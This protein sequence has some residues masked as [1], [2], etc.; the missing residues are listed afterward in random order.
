MVTSYGTRDWPDYLSTITS[1]LNR[2][3]NRSTGYSPNDLIFV[4][5]VKPLSSAPAAHLANQHYSEPIEQQVNA[6]Q[7]VINALERQHESVERIKAMY[8]RSRRAIVL[9][10]GTPVLV[11]NHITTARKQDLS[12][13]LFDPVVRYAYLSKDRVNNYDIYDSTG[14]DRVLIQHNVNVDHLRYV[15]ERPAHLC[16][17]PVNAPTPAD[18]TSTT[19]ANDASAH[20]PIPSVNPNQTKPVESPAPSFSSG[21]G[22]GGSIT[23]GTP[24]P[25]PAPI[26]TRPEPSLWL[27]SEWTSAPVPVTA[28]APA[29]TP[30]PISTETTDTQPELKPTS[31][32]EESQETI[33]DS[34][35]TSIPAPASTPVPFTNNAAEPELAQLTP[36]RQ[37]SELEPPTPP[38]VFSTPVAP[39]PMEP[40][41]QP[42]IQPPKQHPQESDTSTT[43][44]YWPPQWNYES[45]KSTLIQPMEKPRKKLELKPKPKLT[46]VDHIAKRLEV[47]TKSEQ[48]DDELLE[49]ELSDDELLSKFATMSL[50]PQTKQP[51]P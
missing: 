24:T 6:E 11:A 29:P 49:D 16:W 19:A 51:N 33:V 18:S 13:T 10:D 48:I 32:P 21:G 7:R 43:S 8:D 47:E 1:D 22:G 17:Q 25:E 45:P 20:S 42:F 9:S 44:T 4:H 40:V 26:Q 2:R 14:K 46:Y 38:T 15:P 50:N 30:V 3:V 37:H 23:I 34:A 5:N 27:P 36:P 35:P 31:I 28:P 41:T 12:T 39:T